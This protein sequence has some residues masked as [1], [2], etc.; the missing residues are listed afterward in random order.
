MYKTLNPRTSQQVGAVTALLTADLRVQSWVVG[1]AICC[2]TLSN[3]C[4]SLSLSFYTY[5]NGHNHGVVLRAK[6]GYN[7]C[8][9]LEKSLAR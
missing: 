9:C 5:K 4:N 7:V 2:V 8:K 3:Y 1:S 6:Q